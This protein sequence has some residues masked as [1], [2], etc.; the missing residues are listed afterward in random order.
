MKVRYEVPSDRA[1]P[2]AVNRGKPVV[3][4]EE[5]ADVSRAIRGMAKNL[6]PAQDEHAA[7][8]QR[9]LLPAFARS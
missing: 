7:K 1:V 2:L 6:F 9:R 4:D 8:K 5:G 3:L